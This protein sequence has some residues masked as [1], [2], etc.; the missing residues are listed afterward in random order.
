MLF[1]AAV[2][3]IGVVLD[4]D[5]D[6]KEAVVAVPFEVIRV[7]GDGG[8][9]PTSITLGVS[10]EKVFEPNMVVMMLLVLL[11]LLLVELLRC[12]WDMES[13]FDLPSPV[14]YSIV[15]LVVTRINAICYAMR[16]NNQ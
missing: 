8:K 3:C 16:T 5:E 10:N 15:D 2:S 6:D 11:V 1:V 14:R 4:E 9:S 7:G 12:C 13:V